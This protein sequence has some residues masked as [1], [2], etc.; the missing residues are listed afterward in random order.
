MCWLFVVV[1][2]FIGEGEFFGIEVRGK[3]VWLF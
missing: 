3:L 2:Y 1:I